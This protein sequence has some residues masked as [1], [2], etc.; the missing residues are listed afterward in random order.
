MKL[1]PI[2]CGRFKLDG[3]AM[4]GVV[5]KR[6]WQKKHPADRHNLCV[7]AMRALLVETAD[8]KILIDTGMGDK[9]DAKFRS[10]F[11][12]HGSENLANS[13]RA[14]GLVSADIT[15]V[16]LTHLHF[17]HVG[18][19]VERTPGGELVPAFPNATYWVHRRQ[20]DHA[21]APNEKEAASFLDENY[22]PLHDAGVLRFFDQED[23][24]FAW[25]PGIELETT[26]GHTP[27]MLKVRIQL[28]DGTTVIYC[29][30]ALPS[31][32]HLSIPWVMAYD[33]E[34]LKTLE[35]KKALLEEAASENV[36]LFFEHDQDTEAARIRKDERGRYRVAKAGSLAALL[37][38]E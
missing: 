11:E 22:V 17:D 13:L 1:T 24:R 18:G 20:Y 16:L 26:E 37:D 3:G 32:H 36:I 30:D 9:Q 27:A 31:T 14:H 12:P 15:D 25:L 7:W 33:I 38:S 5:P 10:H 23:I 28:D 6:L 35:E 21:L 2:H 29:A 8:R 19:A 34:P 4:F